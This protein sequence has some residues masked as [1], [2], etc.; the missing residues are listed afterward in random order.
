MAPLKPPA[1]PVDTARM[2]ATASQRSRR[3]PSILVAAAIGL[4]LFADGCGLSD[5][6]ATTKV[7]IPVVEI[8]PAAS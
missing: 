4:V 7:P 2:N 8:N 5:G 6:E 3:R 1:C